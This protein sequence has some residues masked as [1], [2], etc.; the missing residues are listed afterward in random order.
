[1]GSSV[2]RFAVLDPST[3]PGTRFDWA[4]SALAARILPGGMAGGDVVPGGRWPGPLAARAA[5]GIHLSGRLL[6]LCDRVRCLRAR[7]PHGR[8]VDEVLRRGN[9][10]GRRHLPAVEPDRNRRRGPDRDGTAAGGDRPG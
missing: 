4:F 6:A 3:W 8:L 7:D 9:A 5:P 2:R 1:M 10:R